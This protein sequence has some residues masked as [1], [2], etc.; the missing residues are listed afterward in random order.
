MD[1]EN[2]F[3]GIYKSLNEITEIPKAEFNKFKDIFHFHN[4]RKEEYWLLSGEKEN[5][6]GI[7]ISGLIRM[8]YIG[9]NIEEYTKDFCKPGD[10][11]AAYSSLLLNEPTELNIQAMVDSTILVAPYEQYQ[12]LSNTHS[13]WFNLN[14]KI[15]EK[16]FLKKEKREK[17][18]LL[19][20]AKDR[21]LQ[22]LSDYHKMD[23]QIP[24]YQIASFLGISP[25]SLS[26]IKKTLN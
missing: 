4:L 13:C 17:D 22:F 12:R 9:N 16:L 8:Y 24:Q 26:R 2:I 10:F 1:K 23:L 20:S 21:Y 3:N 14:A 5:R 11:L 19:L 6:V 7:I 18:F 25:V 15:T